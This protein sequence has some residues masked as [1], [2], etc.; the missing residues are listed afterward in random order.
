MLIWTEASGSEWRAGI[1][2]IDAMWTF[3][4][5]LGGGEG[6]DSQCQASLVFPLSQQI[7]DQFSNEIS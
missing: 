4:V 5:K 1:Y 3:R 2:R 7:Q 6:G